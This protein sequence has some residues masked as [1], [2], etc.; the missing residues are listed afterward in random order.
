MLLC[1]K[2]CTRPFRVQV[3]VCTCTRI[4]KMFVGLLQLLCSLDLHASAPMQPKL[5]CKDRFFVGWK[6]GR[7]QHYEAKAKKV[8]KKTLSRALWVGYEPVHQR[9]WARIGISNEWHMQKLSFIA[10]SFKQVPKQTCNISFT[11]A[12]SVTTPYCLFSGMATSKRLT[13]FADI[14][15]GL[16]FLFVVQEVHASTSPPSRTEFKRSDFEDDN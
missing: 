4:C 8:D 6:D 2:L 5:R 12:L 3:G 13:S 1:G 15:W 11:V 10:M 14:F 9:F 16:D 7:Q